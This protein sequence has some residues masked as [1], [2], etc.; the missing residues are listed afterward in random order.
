MTPQQITF[1]LTG[2]AAGAI[3]VVG[4]RGWPMLLVHGVGPLFFLAVLAAIILTGAWSH[5]GGGWWRILAG[6][7]ICVGA[8]LLALFAFSAVGG[9]SLDIL[10]IPSS[11]D[12]S[13][14]GPDVWIG[15]LAA[16]LVAS[17]CIEFLVYVL[18]GKWSNSFLLRLAV[19]GA[20]TVLVTFAVDRAA[21]SYWTFYGVLL[22][23]GEGLFCA[24]VGA[25]I[26]GSSRWPTVPG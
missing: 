16:A 2:L 5:L 9:Y 8:Y 23:L 24:I 21:H 22:P 20:V 19:A 3:T 1:L 6:I 11:G 15:L 17:A 7:C 18:T 13:R 26:W 14:F 4:A 10:G 25:Q 12:S